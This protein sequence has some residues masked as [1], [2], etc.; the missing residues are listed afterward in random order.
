MSTA[1]AAAG[2][3]AACLAILAAPAGA[4]VR[5]EEVSRAAGIFEVNHTY[6]AYAQD[7]DSDGRQDV[8][9]NRHYGGRLLL[10]HNDG[11]T[12]SPVNRGPFKLRDPHDCDWA[13]VDQDGL[14]D[15][16][17]TAG[18]LK[19][20]NGPNNN[21]LWLQQP[22]GGF[23]KRADEY[24]VEDRFGRGRD[25]TFIDVNGDPF[26]DLY[27]GNA[28]PRQDGRRGANQ[29][30]INEGGQGFR[31]AGGYGVNRPIGGNTVE[32]ADYDR[33]GDEDLLVCGNSGS[34]NRLYLFEN[35][36]GLN[37]RNVSQPTGAGGKCETATLADMDG[38]GDLDLVR[39]TARRIAVRA[40]EKRRFTRTVAERG[41]VSG[42]DLAIGDSTGDGSPDVYVV[43]GGGRTGTEQLDLMLENT[44]G[45]TR[46]GFRRLR[47]P[48]TRH[49]AGDAVGAID[50][51]GNGLMD[52]VVLNGN[53]YVEGPIR[54]IAFEP[55]P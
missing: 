36:A 6:G 19:G 47:I 40:Q 38:D 49:G 41:I 52:Y 32:A 35:V 50:Y 2:V 29:L 51:D 8:L 28:Q 21:G 25:T 48:Q 10:Y 18:G 24:G 26:P 31:R 42:Q 23:V 45:R 20:G 53:R 9:I 44:I 37:F 4:A 7:F 5:A 43:Q 27:V 11:G 17:C 55:R 46:S 16:Y 1:I 14:P 15:F 34:A 54:L 30:F 39:M 13:D 3:G 22:G 12:F 33:D